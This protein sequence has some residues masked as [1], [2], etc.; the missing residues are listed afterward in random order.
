M[1]IYPSRWK[2]LLNTI[3]GFL[4]VSAS[5]SALTV[6]Y[7]NLQTR[8]ELDTLLLSLF[9]SLISI[10]LLFYAGLA[11]ILCIARLLI[12]LP[13]LIADDEGI[14]TTPFLLPW[15][16]ISITWEEIAAISFGP[17]RF[18]TSRA[19]SLAWLQSFTGL[20]IAIVPR[21]E[22]EVLSRHTRVSRT[23]FQR[24]QAGLPAGVF[25]PHLLLPFSGKKVL[26]KLQ[27]TYQAQI[28][29]YTIRIGT[30]T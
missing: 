14:C 3:L 4:F 22:G 18:K 19:A 27:S 20:F 25:I 26:A 9:G 28:E 10:L 16:T 11:L 1:R 30:D 6:V 15:G 5:M 12:P 17:V 29:R 13:T 8:P 21:F 7:G 23:F 24:S 2:L